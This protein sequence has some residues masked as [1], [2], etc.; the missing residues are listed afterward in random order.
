MAGTHFALALQAARFS[1]DTAPLEQDLGATL[2]LL[3]RVTPQ[4]AEQVRLYQEALAHFEAAARVP[5]QAEQ[6]QLYSAWGLTLSHLG[7]LQEDRMLLRQASERLLTALEKNSQNQEVCYHLA[8]V[9]ALLGQGE[10]ALRHLRTCLGND[11]HGL[12]QAQARQDRDFDGIRL[13]P[14]FQ[15]LMDTGPRPVPAGIV[16]PRISDR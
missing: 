3:G 8:R 1:A 10:T 16:A 9:S 4:S 6:D 5:T 12:W 13:W 14:E 15:Q 2:M 11:P 7:K